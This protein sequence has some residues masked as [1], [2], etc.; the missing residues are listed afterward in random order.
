MAGPLLSL[1][2]KHLLHP[3][4]LAVFQPHFDPARMES[5]GCQDILYNPDRPDAGSLVFFQDD[6]DALSRS[7]FN[8]ILAVHRCSVYSSVA[9][10]LAAA[11]LMV[12]C[13]SRRARISRRRVWS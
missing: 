13:N 12:S 4:D 7:N 10:A 6:C 2:R 9:S 8:A 5:G 1:V 3:S 11:W